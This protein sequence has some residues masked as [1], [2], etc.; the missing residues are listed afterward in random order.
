MAPPPSL[1]ARIVPQDYSHWENKHQTVKQRVN[2]FYDIAN[3]PESAEGSRIQ[4]LKATISALQA[5]IGEA[6]RDDIPL[7]ALGSGWSFSKVAATSGLMLNTEYLNWIMEM[8]RASVS[9]AYPEDY[10]HLRFVQCGTTIG[11]LNIHLA[12][13]ELSLKTSGASNGQT[14]AGALSTGTH[15]SAFEVG[16]MQDFIVGIHLVVSPSRH[17]WLERASYPVVHQLFATKL[18]ADLICNDTLFNSALVSFGSFGIIHG[19]LLETEPIYLLEAHRERLPLNSSLRQAMTSLDFTGV[20]LPHPNEQPYHFEI[21]VNPHNLK[22][23]AYIRTMY[24]RPFTK[25]HQL[26]VEDEVEVEDR[27]GDDFV[28][29]MGALTDTIPD[30]TPL[31]V[32]QLV[33]E[34][35]KLFKNKVKTLGEM[36]DYSKTRGKVLSMAMGVPLSLAAKALDT[37]LDVHKTDGPYPGVASMRFVK[38]SDALLAFTRFDPTCVMEL[39]GAN[40]TSTRTFFKRVWHAFD[41]AEIPYTLHWGKANDHLTAARVRR[42]YGENLNH[43][44]TSRRALLDQSG[45]KVFSN[46]F[47]EHLDLAT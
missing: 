27:P 19:V 41:Q 3:P 34:R 31:V 6:I 46:A 20:K 43:W 11:E 37:I 1:K 22:K 17:V 7:R 32:E 40:S 42:M 23:G 18:G 26:E 33:K 12:K 35:L 21:Q 13:K 15:G 8:S 16:A 25:D 4:K 14:I 9:S 45:R 24:K 44:L 28:A 5:L 10:T 29:F 39:D 47:L 38:R 2:R 36:F 30:L